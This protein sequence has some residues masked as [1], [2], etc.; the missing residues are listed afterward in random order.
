MSVIPV[1]KVNFALLW[2]SLFEKGNELAK[3]VYSEPI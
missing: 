2:S 1:I 3:L